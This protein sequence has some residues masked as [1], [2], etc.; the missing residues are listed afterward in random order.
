MM[1]NAFHIL[2]PFTWFF[3]RKCLNNSGRYII[4]LLKIRDFPCLLLAPSVAYTNFGV[5]VP[6]GILDLPL[7]Y[8]PLGML[9][10]PFSD[11]T[12]GGGASWIHASCDVFVSS[13]MACNARNFDSSKFCWFSINKSLVS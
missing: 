9:L 5:F 1:D 12:I 3:H 8:V 4:V 2:L 13:Y 10:E 6:L 11:M 7:A